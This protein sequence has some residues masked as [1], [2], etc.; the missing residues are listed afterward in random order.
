MT[1]SRARNVGA[2]SRQTMPNLPFC[3]TNGASAELASEVSKRRILVVAPQPFYQDRGTPIAVRQVLQALGELGRRRPPDLPGRQRRAI[4]GLSII[5]S[6]NPFGIRRVPIGFSRQKLLLDLPL[7]PHS[8]GSF[9][10]GTTPASTRWRR[11]RSWPRRHEAPTSPAA[12]R[13]AVEP[14]GAARQQAGVPVLAG[15]PRAGVGRALAA[16]PLRSGRGE[17]RPGRPREA[18]GSRGGRSRVALPERPTGAVAAGSS[19]LRERL[20]LSPDRPLVL[21][22]GTFE[23]Y[24]GLPE[25]LRP[26]R[27]YARG[28]RMRPSCWSAPIG[29]GLRSNMSV[30]RRF[31]R[32]ERCGSSSGSRA[33]AWQRTWRWP[34]CWSRP[35]PTGTTFRSRSSITW[36][37][38][39]PIV[40]TDIPTHRTVLAEDRAVLV[41]PGPE[42]L[43]AG[44]VARARRP[45]PR[46]RLGH[47][48][49][50]LRRAPL[51]MEPRSWT[52][53]TN[54]MTRCT[55]RPR[56]GSP[57]T[58]DMST[59]GHRHHSRAQRG[60]LDRR[61][62]H[63]VRAQ[64]RD[65]PR[66]EVLVV[67]DGSTDD[68]AEA[69]RR[70]RRGPLGPPHG[71]RQ[72]GG[73]AEPR[74]TGC[75]RRR[76]SSSS[77]PTAAR[78]GLAGAAPGGARGR[79]HG[80]RRL[81]RP[82]ARAPADGALRLLLR[83]VPRAFP[84]AG[85]ARSPI[86]RR[87]T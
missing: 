6:A 1:A 67:D 10:S 26:F 62:G 35:A 29:T 3:Q 33:R 4:P 8:A 57:Q 53:W 46:V 79:G 82:A 58:R 17:R 69:A 66:L 12:V 86:T 54:S 39:A 40:A 15:A 2:L 44:I 43:A 9:E 25:L 81:A 34:T 76:R 84:P 70:R 51:R 61:A 73:R 80:R 45:S 38:D 77:T 52:R 24:Q 5:R 28:F 14:A 83:L 13:H 59:V 23:A 78:R 21:Y 27:W 36:R 65:G 32:R 20:G 42:A 68:T 72:S 71:R 49:R 50:R 11:R 60:T 56:L 85:A 41:S 30:P 16:P 7:T 31:R 37:P 48:A 75:R 22:S 19:S 64:L 18:C 74:R 63:A 87:A 55:P 47:A